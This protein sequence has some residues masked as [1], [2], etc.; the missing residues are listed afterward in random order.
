MSMVPKSFSKFDS[1]KEICGRLVL[2][3]I[4]FQ[5]QFYVNRLLLIRYFFF[6]RLFLAKTN[7]LTTDKLNLTRGKRTTKSGILTE[8]YQWKLTPGREESSS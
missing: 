4:K 3:S 2:L 8:A 6:F 1:T 7:L 5:F